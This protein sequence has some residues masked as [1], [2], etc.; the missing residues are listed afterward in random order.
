[1]L[2]RIFIIILMFLIAGNVFAQR[3]AKPVHIILDSDMGPD[4]DDVGAITILHALADKGEAKILATIASTK[5]DG[6]AGVLNVFNTYFKRPNIPVG[7]PKGDALTLRDW[8]Y[9]TDTV[10]AKYP[11]QIKTNDDAWDAVKLYRK[12]LAARPDHSVTIVTVGFLTNLSNLLNTKPDAYSSLPG[13]ELVKKKVKLLVCMVGKFPSGAEFNV[14]KDAK[15][16]QNVYTH[17]S[18]PIILSGFEIGEKI[19]AGLPLVHN[20]SIKNDPVKDVFRI[21]IPLAKEDSA[22]R[23]SWDET[24]VLVAIKGYS[25]W[26]SLHKGRMIVADNGSNTWDDNGTGQAYLVEKVDYHVVQELINEL[27]QHQ[28]G[29]RD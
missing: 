8:Q 21:S 27:I 11:H 22:G 2:N 28:P 5:Y 17:W 24:A 29:G 6:V 13:S 10:L 23:M 1:M 19:K 4:Y 14:M 7:V 12:I 16:S 3:A 9:W 26:Y 25:E 15:A 20:P 18:T